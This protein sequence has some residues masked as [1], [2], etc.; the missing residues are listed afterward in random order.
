MENVMIDLETWATVPTAA[1]LSIGAVAF[2][3]H[4]GLG[5]EFYVVVRKDVKIPLTNTHFTTDYETVEW[6]KK[7]SPEAQKVL[8]ACRDHKASVPLTHA[9]GMLAG[10]LL[11][12]GPEVKV[13]G[14]GAEFDNAI[15]HHA[16]A[17]GGCPTPWQ[18]SNS[19]CYR[20]LRALAQHY[21]ATTYPPL[22]GTA[23]H[24][25]D[26]AKHQARC[27]I[28]LLKALR[29]DSEFQWPTESKA[30]PKSI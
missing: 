29:G 2:D 16:Y 17:V 8:A 18:Y 7:Q 30:V 27:A 21:M 15:L 25:L 20:T 1:I 3:Q 12:F 24:A 6:W 5:P 23:H 13:W 22:V 4:A 19:R 9:L 11:Q 10:W 28:Q 14:N 26:D